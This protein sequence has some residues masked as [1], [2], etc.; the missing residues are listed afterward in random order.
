M[1]DQKELIDDF[2]TEI[3]TIQKDLQTIVNTQLKSSKME[4]PLFEKFGQFVDRIYGTAM[5]LGYV[6]IGKYFFAIKGVCYMSSQSDIEVG[7]KKTLRMMMECVENMDKICSCIYKKEE[8]KN[9]NKLFI[10]EIGK[11]DRLAKTEFAKITR[12]SVA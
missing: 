5:T 3:R 9:L 1:N 7:Q 2:V 4:K 8:L 11:A 10:M 12:K 6:E